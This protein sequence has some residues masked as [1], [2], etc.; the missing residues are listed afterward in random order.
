MAVDRIAASNT[1]RNGKLGQRTVVC[2]QGREEEE[3][4]RERGEN[5]TKLSDRRRQKQSDR[6]VRR[7]KRGEEKEERRNGGEGVERRSK[8]LCFL[9]M[10]HHLELGLV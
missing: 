5:I 8:G 1:S 6:R 3:E 4:R 9:R 10:N 2:Y 7:V